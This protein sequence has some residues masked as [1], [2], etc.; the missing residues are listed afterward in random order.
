MTSRVVGTINYVLVVEGGM[1]IV[2][3][4]KWKFNPLWNQKVTIKL[5]LYKKNT[6]VGIEL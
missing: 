2:V 6:I 4:F 1:I 3:L 5:L